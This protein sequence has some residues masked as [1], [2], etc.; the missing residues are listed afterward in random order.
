MR[1]VS[2]ITSA[3]TMI[4]IHRFVV[5]LILTSVF[6]CCGTT[7]VTAE[8]PTASEI[9]FFESR[10]RPVLVEHCYACHNSASDAQGGLA[11][12][13]RAALIA[14]SDHGAVIDPSDPGKSR[15]IAVISH[16]IDGLEMPEGG[17]KLDDEVIADFRRWLSMGAPDPRDSPPTAAQ[18]AE[19][20]SWQ[21]T[22]RRRAKWWSFQPITPPAIPAGTSGNP[23]D[24]FV[25]S[26]LS[27]FDLS[28]APLADP[29]TLIRRLWFNLVG[30][31]PTPDE[32]RHWLDRFEQSND[33][34]GVAS[35]L[36]DHL[37]A[38][39][40]FG[41]RWARHWM[42]WI[43]YAESHGSEGDPSIDHAWMFRD[44]LIR[45][46][47]SD[48][49][50]DQLIREHI[51]GD[52]L[53][54]PRVNDAM[55]INESSIGTAHWRMVF[56]G[57]A[58][59]DALDEKVRFV[60]DQINTFSKAFLGLTVS[61][62]RCHDHKFDAI[63][64]Q[65]YYA[66]FSILGSCRPGR[67][68]IDLPARQNLN[69]EA[70]AALKRS[71]RIAITRDWLD[72]IPA[73]GQRLSE[74][75][76]DS[77]QGQDQ[78]S[79]LRPLLALRDHAAGEDFVDAY[80]QFLQDWQQARNLLEEAQPIRHWHLGREAHFGQWYRFGIG[81]PEH[82]S[83]AGEFA[84]AA[85]GDRAITGIYP[86]G[87]YSH[88]ISDKHPAR[89]TSVDFQLGENQEIWA[90]TIGDAN[91]SLRYVV[92]DYPRKGTVYPVSQLKPK[93]TWQ[94]YDV[95]YWSGDRIHIELATGKDAPLLVK[96][97]DRSWF[98][99]R[100]L[101][102]V[103]RGKRPP[104]RAD[105]FLA[106]IVDDSDEAPESYQEFKSR[107]VA[108]IKKAIQDWGQDS[109]SDAQAL[110]LDLCVKSGLIASNV[111]SLPAA[112]PL[113]QQYRRLEAEIPVVTRVP[114]LDET[115]GR[116]QPLYIRGDHKRPS[117][118]VPRRFLEAI[119]ATPY[120]TQQSG[121]LQLADDLLRDDNPLTRRVMVNRVWHHLF[122]RGIVATPDN[123][124][125]LGSKPTHIELLDWLASDF[126]QQGWS[127]KKLIR[128]IV[129]SHT[130]QQASVPST[131][132][133]EGDPNNLYLSHANVRRLE[134]EAI[135][136]ALLTISGRLDRTR[137]GVPVSGDSKR[138]SVYVRV[139]RNSLDPF[140]RAFDFPEPFST[141]GRRDATNVPAQG[142]TLMN[143]AR[144]A[145]NG[146]ELAKSVLRDER[147]NSTD[148]RLSKI[149]TSLFAREASP[150]ELRLAKR[151]LKSTLGWIDRQ[152]REK[153]ELQAQH[154]RNVSR[155]EEI[156]TPVRRRLEEQSKA[157]RD[158]Q[159]LPEPIS[160]WE[161]DDNLKDSIGDVHG[162][163]HE[164]A[165]LV[166]GQLVL[167]S[168]GYVTTRPLKHQLKEK[169]LEAWVTLDNLKQR[170]GGVM[171]VQSRNGVDF[172]S[173]VFGERDPKQW[174]AGSSN[175][176]R[177]K[178]FNGPREDAAQKRTVHVAIV[179]HGDGRV[180]GYRDGKPYGVTYTSSGPFA[181]QA[182]DT[183]VSFGVRHL[184]A[185]G[186]RMLQG[187]IERAQL[188]DRAMSAAEIA[189]SSG[190][191]MHLVTEADVLATLSEQER[192]QAIEIKKLI[193]A[194]QSRMDAYG[195]LADESP[196]TRSW[197]DLVQ[198][199]LML[200]EFI[201]VR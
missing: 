88:G 157:D 128:T 20:T 6:L 169:T 107:Y 179:Y 18:L 83:R 28:P 96:D 138:R 66:M 31:P 126:D 59:T 113:V 134:A 123:F 164:G 192:Q 8:P 77:K 61:C 150:I 32:L 184:P 5:S 197:S 67:T 199:M 161:F 7:A 186:N 21:S 60:D 80:D 149:F 72:S 78:A 90:R 142:L 29:P 131:R 187:R 25:Q 190:H 162:Q 137:F 48:V 183:I 13:H 104:E 22:L 151:Y 116:T 156:M 43:R 98:G 140:L 143:D 135:R 130:W 155:L 73:L 69:R 55:G 82:P 23:V 15:L 108:A 178:P 111:A 106:A 71:I 181:F 36:V 54:D 159:V 165:R 58:P 84:I 40:H 91:A 103:P 33:R 160:R 166:A 79:L 177:T 74:L 17:A 173:I 57:F 141:M 182:G 136:D 174:L 200:K 1:T 94:T 56:H 52:L 193:A 127:L 87:V 81:L 132:A 34:D 129:T 51:A 105:E 144:V 65:D 11:V 188:Y 198:A 133:K 101:L 16:Q 4:S 117:K 10:I 86:S 62:A 122:G 152:S 112:R 26:K 63:S 168:R 195:P 50:L 92:Q 191:A 125:R 121:R 30:L 114:G 154:D 180:A 145:T 14:G 189:A 93:W 172:D 148:E 19:A 158:Q 24:R 115:V 70:L 146:V 27:E 109:A 45:A 53:E 194:L 9:E 95:S 185:G 171:T 42:D 153:R 64:Q 139:V 119:D 2:R 175:F 38:S 147:L 47:N 76:A 89:L 46:L 49:G 118:D 120:T 167:D 99:I 176:R 75:T 12:D 85:D 196:E 37:L 163:A 44:Y 41:E 170:G 201:Y 68:V 3:V 97:Q 35:E 102:V 110:L 124:G 39:D 100:D